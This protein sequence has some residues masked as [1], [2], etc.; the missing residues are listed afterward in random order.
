MTVKTITPQ[1]KENC[2]VGKTSIEW[3]SSLVN[4]HE[5]Q[6]AQRFDEI[7]SLTINP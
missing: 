7:K 2:A 1:C 4:S 6:N 3:C 5:I